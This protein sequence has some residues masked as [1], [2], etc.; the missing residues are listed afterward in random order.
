MNNEELPVT[1]P[2]KVSHDLG[3]RQHVQTI[4]CVFTLQPLTCPQTANCTKKLLCVFISGDHRLFQTLR[5]GL[6]VKE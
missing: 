2:S 5:E 1:T 3:E 6:G 4:E